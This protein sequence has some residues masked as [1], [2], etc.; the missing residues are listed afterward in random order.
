MVILFL[1]FEAVLSV[2]AKVFEVPSYE[3]QTRHKIR[4]F[5]GCSVEDGN[6]MAKR[7]MRK[8]EASGSDYRISEADEVLMAA[9][10]L[11]FP[12]LNDESLEEDLGKHLDC[13]WSAYDQGF[14]MRDVSDYSRII[15]YGHL[16]ATIINVTTIRG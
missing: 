12:L 16:M 2:M 10:G 8:V 3:H 5:V 15:R 4:S 7:A 1:P 11:E 6:A 9:L 14:R 13:I